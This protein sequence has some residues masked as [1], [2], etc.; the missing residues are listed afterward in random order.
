MPLIKLVGVAN[1]QSP[2]T[3]PKFLPLCHRNTSLG[4]VLTNAIGREN[5]LKCQL[6]SFIL[7]N[8]V[9]APTYLPPWR[10]EYVFTLHQT[11][12]QN[13]LS[14]NSRSVRRSFPPSQKSGRNHR[15]YVWTEELSVRSFVAAQRYPPVWCVH[16][17]RINPEKC[18]RVYSVPGGH[19][20]NFGVGMCRW[21]SR[22][23]SLYQS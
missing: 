1:Q 17:L 22:T 11:M 15:W 13:Q 21:D 7:C 6:D 19:F 4:S 8:H 16:S 18:L 9:L 14:D 23:L 5:L 12:A 3:A 2:V 20:R 10:S